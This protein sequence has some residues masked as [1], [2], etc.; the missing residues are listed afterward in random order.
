VI[1]PSPAGDGAEDEPDSPKDKET[2]AR[3]KHDRLKTLAGDFQ[4]TFLCE[5]L[6]QMAAHD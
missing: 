2:P 6:N 4:R 3:Q 1:P 5:V